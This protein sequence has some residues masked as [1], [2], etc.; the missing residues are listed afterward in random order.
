MTDVGEIIDARPVG[1]FHVGL[2]LLCSTVLLFDGYDLQVM[3]LAVPSV[4]EAWN[5]PPSRFGFALS[6]SLIGMGVGAALLAPLGDRFGRKIMV[7][8]GMVIAGGGTLITAFADSFDHFALWRFVTG[9]GMGALIANVTAL[10]TEYMPARKR[11]ILVTLSYSAVAL[12]GF[13]AGLVAPALLK[14]TD[15]RGLFLFGGGTSLAAAALFALAAP[16]SL[17]FMV[18]K[19][20]GSARLAKTMARFAPGVDAA[21]LTISADSVRKGRIVDLLSKELR[22]RTLTLWGIYVFNIFIIF[23]LT[24]WLP[25]LLK[26]AGW[27]TDQALT[28]S[29]LF[30]LGGV[31][32]SVA[33]ATQVDKGRPNIALVV[34]YLLCA[35]G[36]TGLV[37]TPSTFGNWAGL[38]LLVG[39]GISGAQSLLVALAAAFYP[40][41]LRA[42]GVGGALLVGRVGAISAPLLGGV[43]IQHYSPVGALGLMI[44]PALIC[45]SGSLLVRKGWL[46]K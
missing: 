26:S 34:G 42:T 29:V 7:V 5:A 36:L 43:I 27:P 30:Q 13:F 16:E 20:P 10:L 11:T 35:A 1:W 21:A 23:M 28:G 41:T 39:F 45:A 12:G 32:G 17:K 22:P 31:A 18:A 3:A 9:V 25:T 15:W 33:L 44:I 2:M 37:F 14:V 38:M 24:S 40:V 4:A 19:R 46:E 8:G 6:T